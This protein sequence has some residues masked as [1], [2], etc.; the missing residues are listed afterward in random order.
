MQSLKFDWPLE[1]QVN[2]TSHTKVHIV[3]CAICRA[4]VARSDTDVVR[5][6]RPSSSSTAN[7]SSVRLNWAEKKNKKENSLQA[8]IG[9]RIMKIKLSHGSESKSGLWLRWKLYLNPLHRHFKKANLEATAL[10]TST[11]IV[12]SVDNKEY[13]ILDSTLTSISLQCLA[14]SLED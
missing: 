3:T 9:C 1:R 14:R 13:G 11:M 6:P 4:S 12:S 2:E 10:S 8:G 7:C 5:L